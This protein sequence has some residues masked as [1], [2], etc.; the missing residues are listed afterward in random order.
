MMKFL[1][2]NQRFFYLIITIV[3]VLSFTFFGTSGTITYDRNRDNVAF[4]DIEGRE[5]K[6]SELNTLISF[7]EKEQTDLFV[8]GGVHGF[9]GLNDGVFTKDFIVKG[10]IPKL[11]AHFSDQLRGEFEKTFEKEKRFKMYTHPEEKFINTGSVWTYFA[12]SL[13][14]CFHKFLELD[15]IDAKWLQNRLDLILEQNRFPPYL[16]NQIMMQQQKQYKWITPDPKLP[17]LD[18]SLFGHHGLQDWLGKPMLELMG[19]FVLN[20]AALADREGIT[21]SREEALADLLYNHQTSYER[22]GKSPAYGGRS[23]SEAWQMQLKQFHLS[24]YDAVTLWQKVLKF[25][26]LIESRPEGVVIDSLVFKNYQTYA[27][28]IAE[29]DI[30]KIPKELRIRN[31]DDLKE[32][33]VYLSSVAKRKERGDLSLPTELKSLAEIEAATPSL[34]Y[35]EFKILHGQASKKEIENQAPL[36]EVL[37]WQLERKNQE[38]LVEEFSVLENV[39]E[40]FLKAIEELPPSTKKKIDVFTRAKILEAHP[41]R[42]QEVL[43][44]VGTEEKT[45]LITL[46]GGLPPLEGIVDRDRFIQALEKSTGDTFTFSG[47]GN[48]YH[49][50]EVVEKGEEKKLLTLE[51]AKARGILKGLVEKKLE[52]YFEANRS[53]FESGKS[54][55]EVKAKVARSYFEP[56]TRSIYDYARTSDEIDEAQIPN[57]EADTVASYRLLKWITDE[58]EKVVEAARGGEEYPAGIL[59]WKLSKKQK[60]FKRSS[61]P[62]SLELAFAMTPGNWSDLAIDPFGGHS[63]YRLLVR[64]SED[65]LFDLEYE[66]VQNKLE[67]DAASFVIED[68]IQEGVRKGAFVLSQ[69]EVL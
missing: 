59:G 2:K 52:A 45:L 17:Y 33:E 48:I 11:E 7:L 3:I 44:R 6:E 21:V 38:I 24:E 4:V 10:I 36:R 68:L 20:G 1:R 30:Y 12:P 62:A 51:E 8:Y 56:L 31:F 64:K 63:F 67:K 19:Q 53:E 69:K 25:R 27:K 37:N 55:Q 13:K 34:I 60:S 16:L 42:F 22:F 39:Q 43:D 26:R 49:K 9:N 18:L 47:D 50:I 41:E 54:F 23:S 66:K 46:E 35:R 15:K 40:D 57:S 28:E 14:K 61:S 29:V 5:V 65:E 58:R 32:F